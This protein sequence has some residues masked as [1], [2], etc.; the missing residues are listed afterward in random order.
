M[1]LFFS[2]RRRHTRLQGDWSSDVCSSDLFFLE[3]G[4]QALDD[5]QAGIEQGQQLLAEQ[6]QRQLGAALA[7]E[8]QAGKGR[9]PEIGRA[10]CRER[11]Q[12]HAAGG[13]SK[14][15]EKKTEEG[16]GAAL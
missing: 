16:R 10:S 11:G 14:R 2:S 5:A 12:N 8:G 15:G 6:H 9:R 4:F 1:V 7:P 3:Q 13:A